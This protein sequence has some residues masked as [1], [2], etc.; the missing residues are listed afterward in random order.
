MC[1]G[2]N[3]CSDAAHAPSG[4][5]TTTGWVVD[6]LNSSLL[7]SLHPSS[8]R[9]ASITAT[10]AV[11]VS[12]TPT[13][14]VTCWHVR[15]RTRTQRKNPCNRRQPRAERTHDQA[16]CRPSY[17]ARPARCPPTRQAHLQAEADPEEGLERLAGVAAR[18]DLPL[19]A[20]VAEPAGHQDAV[21]PVQLLLRLG[22]LLRRRL[23][24]EVLR[25]HPAVLELAVGVHRRVAQR[26]HNGQVGVRPPVVLAHD[27][28][29]HLPHGGGG[30]VVLWSG[31]PSSR[32]GLRLRRGRKAGNA[33]AGR[34]WVEGGMVVWCGWW[35]WDLLLDAVQL[36]A[37]LLPLVDV[38][39]ALGQVHL[40][41][42]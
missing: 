19:D 17:P 37:E 41:L 39:H 31:R 3:A 25:V 12:P 36:A 26:A 35:G 22:A 28:D 32:G 34:E 7:A 14:P 1:A 6:L 38:G 13:A 2:S 10:C 20:A 15:A 8:V 11:L 33:R 21:A 29:A 9:A 23:V 27:G 16:M 4:M 40:Q 42:I 5:K 24:L 30:T 18:A